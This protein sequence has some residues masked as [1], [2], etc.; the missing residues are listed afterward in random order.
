M[1][2]VT[3]CKIDAATDDTL[4][5]FLPTRGDARIIAPVGEMSDGVNRNALRLKELAGG[6]CMPQVRKYTSNAR[7]QAAYRRRRKQIQ[8]GVLVPTDL[9]AAP[10]L[11]S[12]PAT[13]RWRKGIAQAHGLLV[14]VQQEMQDYYD[15]RS[16]KWQEGEKGDAFQERLD[17]I[18]EALG[19]VDELQS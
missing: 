9:P 2:T 10:K 6:T 18:E 8:S 17:Q 3:G 15:E 12:M 16:E 11:T 13:E 7:R 1:G 4:S 5:N 14:L 19:Y